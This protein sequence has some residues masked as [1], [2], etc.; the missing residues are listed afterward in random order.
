MNNEIRRLLILSMSLLISLRRIAAFRNI[1]VYQNT[2][3]G[4]NILQRNKFYDSKGDKLQRLERIISNRGVGSR[5]DVA[6]LF[7]QG[8][9]SI[10]GKT[11]RSGA[12]KYSTDVDVEIDGM[13]IEGVRELQS[14]RDNEKLFQLRQTYSLYHVCRRFVF[15]GI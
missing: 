8:R 12:D 15:A 7:K 2:I 13:P 14:Y 9:V 11:V 3:V 10:K 1:N 5:N 4:R 6:K